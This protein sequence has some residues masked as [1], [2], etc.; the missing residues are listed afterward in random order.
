M[1]D[2]EA[3][4]R[5]ARKLAELYE[6]V[7]VALLVLVARRLAQGLEDP[8]WAKARLREAGAV[9]SEARRIVARLRRERERE[10][11][12]LI[13]AAHGGGA[14]AALAALRRSRTRVAATGRVT[15]TLSRRDSAA[16]QA[17]L[18][19]ALSGRLAEGDLRILR[20]AP[21]LYRAVIGRVTAQGLVDGVTRRATA[22]A[23]LDLFAGHGVT[24]FVDS[25]GKQWALASYAEM[26]CRT[27]A[28]NAA[29][30][31]VFD[32]VLAQGRDLVIISGSPS[33]CDMCAP[34]EGQV[35]S[36]D[37]ATPGYP[38]LAE[39]EGDGLFHPS[40][41]V[42][43]TLVLGPPVVAASSRWYEGEVVILRAASGDELTVTPNHPILTPK[44][45]VAAGAL[46]EG[47]HIVRYLGDERVMDSVD[48]DDEQVPSTIE[49]VTAALLKTSAVGAVRMP[50]SSEDFHGDG[51]GGEVDVV[52]ANGL[53]R[54][55]GD[56]ALREPRSE[57]ALTGSLVATQTFLAE[58]TPVEVITGAAH[59]SHRV[60]RGSGKGITAIRVHTAQTPALRLAAGDGRVSV[61][62]QTFRERGLRDSDGPGRLLLRQLATEIT[63]DSLIEVSRRDFAGHVYNLQTQGGWFACN[64]IVTHNCTHSVAP[65]IEGLTRRSAT[66]YGDP[67]RY[68]AQQQQRYL[69]RGVRGWKMRQAGALDDLA[70]AKAKAHV[71]EWQGRLREH[72][73]KHDLPRLRYREQIGKAI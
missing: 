17:A 24:G 21:D 60:V 13:A 3:I 54:S 49:Q 35:L 34:W 43:E 45:W 57:Q 29:R 30:Q 50:V 25:A 70:A 7:E 39:A 31:G 8:G 40:C 22:Q 47:D 33:C 6:G 73:A 46:H 11:V 4:T 72:V 5:L 64:G 59:T 10:V 32:A 2:P 67:E 23:A 48:P 68:A 66:Q 12:A 26:A 15:A 63:L 9:R 44:G 37:G 53:L 62:P 38:T 1:L 18:S 58:G 36:L 28:H 16:A 55:S 19:R 20:A 41:V 51:L 42:G 14:A 56:A 65:Y 69:E 27:A 61:P 52:W 71:R